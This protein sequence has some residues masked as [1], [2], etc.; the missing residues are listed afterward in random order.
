VTRTARCAPADPWCACP[1]AG[2]G[3][4]AAAARAAG[5]A[6]TTAILVLGAGPIEGDG[7]GTVETPLGDGRVSASALRRGHVSHAEQR[8]TG[9]EHD[10]Q[11]HRQPTHHHA[12]VER[13]P[14]GDA[15]KLRVQPHHLVEAYPHAYPRVPQ[16]LARLSAPA[17]D[18]QVARVAAIG[19]GRALVEL[20]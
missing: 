13:R 15:R 11:S 19:G 1:A 6:L 5:L 3:R 18:A 7:I 20:A 12:A 9:C 10:E 4:R 17:I 2:C 8:R 16:S 14:L